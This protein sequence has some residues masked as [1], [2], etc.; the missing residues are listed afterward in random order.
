MDNAVDIEQENVGDNKAKKE[1][2][3]KPF[4]I[5]EEINKDLADNNVE[6]SSENYLHWKRNGIIIQ[7]DDLTNLLWCHRSQNNLRAIPKDNIVTTLQNK[8]YGMKSQIFID[9]KN[10]IKFDKQATDSF[11]ELSR[12][13]TQS[14]YHPMYPTVLKHIC[15]TVK[16]RIFGLPDYCPIFLNVYGAAGSGKSECVKS[17]F[18]IFPHTLKSRVSNAADLFN[19]E[20]QTF[21]FVANYVITMDELTG[22]NKTDMNKLKN[23]ID[24]EKIVYRQLG[25]NKIVEGKNNA[26]LIGTSN[27]RLQNTLFVDSD[28][29]KWCEMD[30][31][32]YPDNEVPEKM[33]KPLHQFDW[34]NLWRSVNENENSPFHNADTYHAFRRW[35]E[36]KCLTE[37]PTVEFIK[38]QVQMNGG[39]FMPTTEIWQQYSRTVQDK[40]MSKPKLKELLEKYGY[41]PHRRNDARGFLVPTVLECKY[42]SDEDKAQFNT[43]NE[44]W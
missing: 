2:E 6:C 1:V 4:N 14:N 33:V 16:R 32:K 37:T 41:T 10:K 36:Q 7:I 28:L 30:I 44:E 34:L 3:K 24:C 20:R 23:Q 9:F 29:R 18:S 39:K 27:T 19:D 35:T 21:R 17:M 15:W 42:F 40:Q 26:Q 8:E 38:E 5:V 12:L 25:F 31:F 43:K 22:L 11:D 13:V